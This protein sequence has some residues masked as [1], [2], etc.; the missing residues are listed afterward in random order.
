VPAAM[1]GPRQPFSAAAAERAGGQSTATTYPV[2]PIHRTVAASG[3]PLMRGRRALIVRPRAAR[4]LEAPGQAPA[5]SSTSSSPDG[6][7]LISPR[8]PGTARAPCWRLGPAVSGR[9]ELRA[10]STSSSPPGYQG[11][12]PRGILHRPVDEQLASPAGGPWPE[13][14][15]SPSASSSTGASREGGGAARND[16]IRLIMSTWSLFD[17]LSAFTVASAMKGPG[18][19]SWPARGRGPAG[20]A[21]GGPSRRR[22]TGAPLVT[23]RSGGHARHAPRGAQGHRLAWCLPPRPQRQASS[24]LGRHQRR[25]GQRGARGVHDLAG[26]REASRGPR[27]RRRTVRRARRPRGRRREAPRVLA[28]AP[29]RHRARR[30]AAL[31]PRPGLV[32]ELPGPAVMGGGSS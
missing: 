18:R 15:G 5:G 32:D 4:P 12:A 3:C 25:P 16:R 24:R 2:T 26:G 22:A 17:P 9:V 20:R 23:G 10:S 29:P 31:S 28:P 7:H 13:S 14:S 8:Q 27:R 30:G 19:S 6:A 11:T 1:R 21:S